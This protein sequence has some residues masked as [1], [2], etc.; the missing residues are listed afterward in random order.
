MRVL[1]L[2]LLAL[3]MAQPVA[4]TSP[5]P[6]GTF[7]YELRALGALAGEA[8]LTISEPMTI[9]KSPVRRVRIE[10][11]TAG[12]A[13]RVYKATGDG[14]AIV[15]AE[16]Q[17]MRVDWTAIPKGNA[18]DARV[19]IGPTGI[20]G[21]YRREGRKDEPIDYKTT[22]WPM[23]A[24]S[25]Y[26]SIPQQDLTPGPRDDRPFFDGRKLGVIAMTVGT[27]KQIHVPVGLRLAVPVH[28]TITRPGRTR[29]VTFWVGPEDRVLY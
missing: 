14:T 2:L 16:H 27:P 5:D 22:T 26:L 6:E 13:G 20:K 15:N 21:L 4:A 17:P 23:D 12:L 18:R 1:I 8:V 25:A 7:R 24:V 19:K 3:S 29:E 10:A 11:R 28:I 9:G